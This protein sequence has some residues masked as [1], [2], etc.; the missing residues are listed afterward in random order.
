MVV[1]FESFHQFLVRSF[2][3]TRPSP[4]GHHKDNGFTDQRCGAIKVGV[5]IK[6]VVSTVVVVSVV[7]SWRREQNQGFYQ[8]TTTTTQD[9][10][11]EEEVGEGRM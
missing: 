7:R 6:E 1:V 4:F 10:D 9:N 3:H 8:P 11:N 2:V 5:K